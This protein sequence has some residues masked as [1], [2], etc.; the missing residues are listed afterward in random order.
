MYKP[1]DKACIRA[2]QSLDKKNRQKKA[3]IFHNRRK[4]Y[5]EG[6]PQGKSR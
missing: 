5:P 3:A 4:L 2:G 1:S 6:Y